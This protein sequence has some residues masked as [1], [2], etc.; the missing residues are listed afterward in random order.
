MSRHTLRQDRKIRRNNRSDLRI[1]ARRLM[2]RHHNDG[3]SMGR[4][5]NGAEADS[6]GNN[7]AAVFMLDHR[8]LHPAAHPV[9]LIG[10]KIIVLRPHHN[11]QG[12]LPGG[13]ILRVQLPVR[14]MEQEGLRRRKGDLIP[15]SDLSSLKSADL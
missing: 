14:H 7:I 5:L 3:I 1:A 13:K 2:I 12:M 10:D 15:G 4:Y 9:I 11:S 6:V 8:P